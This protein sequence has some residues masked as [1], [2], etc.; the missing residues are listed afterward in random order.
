MSKCR[1]CSK[2]QLTCCVRPEIFVT[3]GDINRIANGTGRKDFYHLRPVPEEMKHYYGSPCNVEKGSEIYF[4]YL[5]NENG[6]RN[7]L[8]KN[9]KNE[10]CFLTQDGCVLPPN[11]R[12]ILCRLYPFDWNDK[13]EI[14]VAPTHCP[15]NFFKDEQEIRDRVCLTEE[16]AK[17][18]VCLLYDEIMNK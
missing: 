9:E 5:F 4:Q 8:K 13:K 10:C 18:L 16:E 17:R 1:E 6:R 7:I 12:P 11:I 2:I 15:K 3:N 14:W